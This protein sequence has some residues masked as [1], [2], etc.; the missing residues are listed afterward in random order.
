LGPIKTSVVGNVVIRGRN[1]GSYVDHALSISSHAYKPWYNDGVGSE[2]YVSDNGCVNCGAEPW[3]G[4][5]DRGRLEPKVKRNI[6]PVWPS[7]LKPKS[8]SDILTIVLNN[9][10]ARPAARDAVDKRIVSDVT[11]GTGR[12]IDSQDEVNGWPSLKVE[13]RSLT[14][15]SALHADVDAD[16]YTNMEEWL[17]SLAAEVA[18]TPDPIG[19]EAPTGLSSV[20]SNQ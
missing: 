18:G 11:A 9:S 14:L 16:G 19:I 6:A 4:V 3:Q 1:S 17:H 13:H 10:G 15:P 7:G 12:F 2:V 8:S 20:N 5:D